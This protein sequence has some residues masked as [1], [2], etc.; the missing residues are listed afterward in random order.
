MHD[1]YESSRL[2]SKILQDQRDLIQT[3]MDEKRSTDKRFRGLTKTLQISKTIDDH[4]SQPRPRDLDSSTISFAAIDASLPV[5][6]RDDLEKYFN[7]IT[8][9]L[10]D[11]DAC[12]LD[13]ESSRYHRISDSAWAIHS[14]EIGH[15]ETTHGRSATEWLQ[16]QILK[17]RHEAMYVNSFII[18][19]DAN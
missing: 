7:L 3:L 15:F 8:K 1:T 14:A 16:R 6:P 5:P 18:F 17:A 2:D 13:L 10:S 11:I 19:T 9:I 4:S 12:K